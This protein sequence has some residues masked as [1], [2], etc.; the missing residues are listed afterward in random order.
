MTFRT[1]HD[2]LEGRSG[3]VRNEHDHSKQRVSE[4][5]SLLK[6]SVQ[7]NKLN[8]IL[9]RSNPHVYA[10]LDYFFILKL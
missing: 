9:I 2:K 3:I 10:Y 7:V 1:D 5:L 6:Q 8:I 4:I